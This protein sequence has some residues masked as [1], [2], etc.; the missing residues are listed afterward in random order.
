MITSTYRCTAALALFCALAAPVQSEDKPPV[1]DVNAPR[2]KTTQVKFNTTEGTWLDVDVAPD[3]KTLAFSMMGDIYTLPISG[4]NAK[5]IFSGKGFE[6]QPRFSPDGKRISFTSDRAGGDN[7]WTANIDGSELQ[8]VT[9]ESFRLL[10]NAE[11]SSDGEYLIAR[12]HFTSGRSLGAGEMW[13]YH[14][15]G[16]EGLKLTTRKNDQ[17]D[18]GQ[19]AISPNGRYVYFSED[20]SAGGAFAY[21]KDPHDTIYVIR[22]LDRETGELTELID[23]Q[24]GAIAPTP[25]P[26]GKS[27]AFVRRVREKTTL[28]VMDLESGAMRLVWDGP[29]GKGM[30][31]DQQEAWA[32]FGPYPNMSFTP[33][34]ASI[35][36]WSTGKLWRVPLVPAPDS[37][38][39]ASLAVEIPFSAEVS[40][41]LDQPVRATHR[42]DQDESFAPKLIRDVAT[43][44]DGQTLIFH[45]VGVLWKKTL[46][47]GAPVR[48]S[49]AADVFEYSPSFSPDGNSV[50]YTSWSDVTMGSLRTIELATNVVRTL[51][52]QPAVYAS[53]SYSKDGK[54]LVFAINAGGNLIDFRYGQLGGVYTMPAAGGAML[55]VAKSGSQPMFDA[56]GA[57]VLYLTGGGLDKKLM[58]VGLAGEEPR[59]VFNLK[60]ADFAVPSPDGKFIAFTEL[61]DAYVAPMPATG[62]AIDLSRDTK[63]LPVAKVSHDVGSYLH[64]S[65]D[66]SAL[67]WM[68]GRRYFTRA[69]NETLAF[70]PN[71]PKTPTKAKDL[72]GID[73]GL[74][75]PLDQPKA[76]DTVAFT[77]ARII[78]MKGKEV[79]E[80]GTVLVQGA[81]IIAV[82]ANVDVPTGAR[83]IDVAGKTIMPGI[84]D[85]HAH[86]NHFHNGP[87]AQANWTYYANLAFGITTMHDPSA[88]TQEVFSQSELVKAG[89]NVGPRVFST[90]T[91]LYGADGDFKAEINSLD[92]ARAHLR[93]LKAQGAWSVKSYNQ[94]RRDQRQQINQ[95]ARELGMTVVMEGGSTY[96]HNLT[97][98]LDGSTGIEHNLPVAPLYKDVIDTWKATDVRNTP[99]LVVNYGGLNG[100]YWFYERDKIWE[101]KKLLQFFPRETLDARSIRRQV[102][103]E[104]D[105]YHIEV[106]KA[107]KSLSD[108]GIGIQVGGHGQL[109]G[110]AP[111]WEIWMLAQGGM[112]PHD[113]LKA[114]TING[115]DYLGLSQDIGSIEPGKL[116]DLIVL[117]TNPLENIRATADSKYV[118]VNGRLFDAD[119]MSEIGGLARAK[120]E[121]YWQRHGGVAGKALQQLMGPTAVCHCPKG[122]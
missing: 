43:S 1:W 82:G 16:G 101:N 38:S 49:D 103:P 99:T 77:N 56:S 112:S 27:L 118:M 116:A 93:R 17:Q 14:K 104:W 54:Q 66:S 51:T 102:T 5:R 24:G 75:V 84:V 98:I 22:R 35:V 71:A 122:H 57:R 20:T 105:Y 70:L 7:I 39:G 6:V 12:K 32:I 30:S 26:D 10:N 48:L 19:P 15:T 40:Q 64:W 63:A 47:N 4:G 113:A 55:R 68:V 120:P 62:A 58:S 88:N 36:L 42:I 21:N 95:A 109:Q 13:L 41:T 59:T 74:S 23:I 97:M 25:S 44:P 80:C 73:V 45:A 85:A 11:F 61:F 110:L 33:D 90:G 69:L 108:A 9:K 53:P 29:D 46:P 87:S 119:T 8:Q 65:A 121:F 2:G 115:A 52:T 100:E 106:S 67:H 86:A 60:Y 111:H 117:N 18:A 114:A 94:P 81:K 28:H 92:D 107:V 72:P 78:T 89:R 91:I 3:G 96:N 37:V 31:H 76:A 50:V 34:S 79:I 83:V